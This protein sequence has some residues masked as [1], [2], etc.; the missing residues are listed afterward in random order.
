MRICAVREFFADETRGRCNHLQNRDAQKQTRA[1][2]R[3]N[4]NL[5]QL[6]QC[7]DQNLLLRVNRVQRI[8]PDEWCG[9]LLRLKDQKESGNARGIGKRSSQGRAMHRSHAENS[10]LP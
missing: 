6:A 1:R 7:L 5:N 8:V 10:L 9:P 2:I 4:H 3:A